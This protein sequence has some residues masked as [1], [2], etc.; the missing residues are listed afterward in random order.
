MSSRAHRRDRRRPAA[1]TPG[2]AAGPLSSLIVVDT[3]TDDQFSLLLV[4]PAPQKS[5]VPFDYLLTVAVPVIDTSAW[6]FTDSSGND[7]AITSA[8]MDDAGLVEIAHAGART[9]DCYLT[10]PPY[11]DQFQAQTG[12]ANAG[13]TK[14]VPLT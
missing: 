7:I 11:Q 9:G 4:K 8:E 5:G 10:I 2:G 13:G 6:N 14:T 1:N 3:G 12:Y